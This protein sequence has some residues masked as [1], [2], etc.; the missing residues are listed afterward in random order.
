MRT[1]VKFCGLVRDEDVDTAVSLGVDAVGFV[2]YAKSPRALTI[3]AARALRRRLP[4]YVCAV[5]LFVNEAPAAVNAAVASVGLDVLQFHGDE[6]PQACD[7]ACPSGVAYWRAVRMKGAND[8]LE[9]ARLFPQ[10][11][12]LL[13]DAYSEAY[14]GAGRRFDWSWAGVQVSAPLIL[15]GGLDA[16]TVGAGIAAVRP[17]AVDVSSGIQG[18]D[19]RSKDTKRMEQFMAAVIAA[20]AAAIAQRSAP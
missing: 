3:E 15:S 13:L 17:M 18:D 7:I 9:S 11:E 4:S 6:T 1:R 10:A 12:A 14:G 20:D 19:P 8:L 5:G 2:F 16:E